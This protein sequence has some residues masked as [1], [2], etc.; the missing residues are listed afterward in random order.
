MAVSQQSVLVFLRAVTVVGLSLGSGV[1][2]GCADT[3]PFVGTDGGGKKGVDEDGDGYDQTVDCDDRD[4]DVYPGAPER[5]NCR[6]DNCDG[7][8]DEGTPNEDLDDDG[9]CPST[10]DTGDCEGNPTRF[11][12]QAE[13]YGGPKGQANGI[14]DNCNGLIDEGLAG[15][16]IDGDGFT[17]G[18]GDC[19]DN[20]PAI[21]PGAIEVAGRECRKAEDCPN[22]KCYDGFC[23]CTE[24]DE[25]SSL[26]ACIDNVQCTKPGETCVNKK[27]RGTWVCLPAQKGMPNPTLKVCRD[28]ADNDC[29]GKTDELPTA[30]DDPAT[31]DQTKAVDYGKAIEI[32]DT[33]SVCNVDQK[34][35]GGLLCVDGTCRRLMSA[36]LKGDARGRAIVT[37]FAVKGPIKPRKNASMIVLSSGLAVYDPK[38]T[39]P[40]QGTDFGITDVDPDP[41]ISD[42]SANDLALFQLRILVPTNARS[43]SFDFQF[44][45]TEYP[46]YLGTEFNDTFWVLLNSKKF[47]GNI[48][49]DKAGTPIRLN[50]AFFDICD[51]DP[52]H[53][54]T[55]QYCTKPASLLTGTGYAKDCASSFSCAGVSCGGSTGWLTTTSPVEPGEII[56]LSFYIFD[57]G[58]GILDSSVVIDN[59]HWS[60][61]PAAKPITGPD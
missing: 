39:C 50:N 23:R 58:D 25:C 46:D 42:K 37:E 15:S 19:N 3:D 47:T 40:Q 4:P 10:G 49:F 45:T 33:D 60:L 54:Q 36:T 6:D 32:C 31:L 35:P 12:T 14:D 1:L 56:T 43:F 17:V 13:D 2:A 48:S 34:C 44:L 9:F 5:E 30:C 41:T 28:S 57:K 61:T 59:F 8:L 24:D 26:E 16:D 18:G 20:D 7:R 11:P 29:D 51:P 53:P 27:C 21:N 55:Q 52:A 38:I 22:G